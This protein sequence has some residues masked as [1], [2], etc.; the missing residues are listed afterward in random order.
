MDRN[1]WQVSDGYPAPE[2]IARAH[3]AELARIRQ[4]RV[5]AE[6]RQILELEA[7]VQHQPNDFAD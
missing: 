4:E 6:K 3:F 7:I 5:E 1:H 2:L